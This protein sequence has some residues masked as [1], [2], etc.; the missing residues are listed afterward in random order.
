M[1]TEQ[2]LSAKLAGLR[3]LPAETEWYESKEA[4]RNFDFDDI[5]RYFSA[6]SNEANLKQQHAAWLVFGVR[7]D[8]TICGSTYRAN[9]A[10]LDSLKHEIA[11][12]TNGL[13]FQEIYEL[14]HPEGR[15]VMFQ[16][17][18]APAG[19]PTS[20]KG[21]FYGR[22]GESLAPLSLHELETIRGQASVY[23]WTAEVCPEATVDDIDETALHIAREKFIVKYMRRQRQLD[24]AEQWD[25][26]TFLNK[27]RLT[28]NGQITRTALL[29]LGKPE[30]AHHLSPHPAQITWRLS[31]EEQAYEH[32]GPPFLLAVESVFQQIRN[33]KFR[34][35]PF[36][37]LIP[38]EITKYDPK[39]VLEALNNCVAHQDYA[40]NA[41]IIVTETVDNLILQ[42]I[43]GFFD[44]TLDDYVLHERTP[45][46][47]RN[48][49]LTQAMVSLDMIDTMGMGIRRMFVE[50]RRRFL[51]L[52]EY[53]LTDSNHVSMVIWGR[54]IDE[55]YS[56]I[57]IERDD[58]SLSEVIALDR[59]QKGMKIN[60]EAARHLRKKLLV[61]GR[62]PHLFVSAR[63]AQLTERKA[64]YTKHK[65]FD[66]QYYKDLVTAF[67]GQ[68][69]EAKP[70]ELQELLLEKFSDLLT[71]DQKKNQARALLYDMSHKDQTIQN[72]G[73]R[74]KQAK[75]VLM[76]GH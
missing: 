66:K 8:Q 48:P 53:D 50:Q 38:V 10:S 44:G 27:A 58:L 32:F 57:L 9:R 55:N 65:A 4:R 37:R 14:P 36:N 34:L 62:Y 47:Y 12:H 35:Q 70:N 52:P 24:G 21:H 11:S 64:E 17:P 20:W 40:M 41:R 71:A 1:L 7:N 73:G 23:D 56:K 49:F 31:A 3:R 6:L 45:E 69:G 22:D 60:I 61:E 68:H 28:R 54:S 16:I 29:L 74:G 19:I 25:T 2:E 67:L 30:S 75:W 76:R 42:N 59:V 43:G 46:R 51:P 33:V 5:G 72:I 39:I 18:P 15:V 13:T 26:I 63:I